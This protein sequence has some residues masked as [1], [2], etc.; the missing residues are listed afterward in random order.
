VVALLRA[1]GVQ[2]FI[3]EEAKGEREREWRRADEGRGVVQG[4]WRRAEELWA[5]DERDMEERA[6]GREEESDGERS[7]RWRRRHAVAVGGGGDDGE[8]WMIARPVD[9]RDAEGR[10]LA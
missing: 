1:Y 9:Y 6:R 7:M 5:E 10:S 2:D 4:E 3:A 8:A